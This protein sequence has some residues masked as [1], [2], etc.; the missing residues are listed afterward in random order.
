MNR[1]EVY[2]LL[3][4][5]LARYRELPY[6]K[7]TEFVGQKSSRIVAGDDANS[8]TVE[9]RIRWYHQLNEDVTVECMVAL[10]D[11]G[12]FD[13]LDDMFVVPRSA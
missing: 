9:V 11:C 2:K 12:P 3:S 4:T 7:L 1:A 5:E 8:Y 10:S 13:R 6:Q